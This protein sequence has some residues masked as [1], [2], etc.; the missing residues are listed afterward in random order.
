[1]HQLAFDAPLHLMTRP[2]WFHCDLLQ[3]SKDGLGTEPLF[4]DLIG[5]SLRFTLVLLA[6]HVYL[7]RLGPWAEGNL[8]VTVH[9]W[10][11]SAMA[12][13]ACFQ[14]GLVVTVD[15]AC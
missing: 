8:Q 2:F 4:L 12:R 1:M 6:L 11:S 9:V 14:R 13:G 10:R 7:P 15:I 5:I 3:P